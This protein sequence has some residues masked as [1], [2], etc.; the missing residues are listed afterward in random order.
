MQR[1]VLFSRT[2]ATMGKKL[3]CV[4][5]GRKT[6]IFQTWDECESYV[7]G[8][9][10]AQYKSFQTASEAQ[11]YMSSAV[12]HQRGFQHAQGSSSS[13]AATMDAVLP[14]RQSK[15]AYRTTIMPP[16][17]G[18]TYTTSS[19]V[20]SSSGQAV[21]TKGHRNAVV[22]YCDGS[23][24]G[25]GKTG[26]IAGVGVYFGDNDPRNVSEPLAGPTQ[27]NQRAELTAAIRALESVPVNQPVEIRTDSMYTIKSMTDWLPAWQKQPWFQQRNV[28][29]D[30]A[31]Q[32]ADLM[33]QLYDRVS[34]RA[35]G[36][37]KWT[38]VYG[39]TG[40]YGNEQADELARRGA[41]GTD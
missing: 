31:K 7:K 9:P 19:S 38:H 21:D 28:R 29:G 8:F 39:H 10:G 24:R 3:Y 5:H 34:E 11:E 4:K 18:N 14:A 30:N 17:L 2:F 25:N 6:G 37:I 41:G 40:E 32:N 13:R 27:T 22:V 33:F 15:P 1:A 20:R 12:E 26:A 36:L 16:L 35:P 23:C